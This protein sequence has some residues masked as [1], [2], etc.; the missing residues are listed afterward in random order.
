MIGKTLG[1]FE[2]LGTLGQGGMGSIYRARDLALIA[3][4]ATCSAKF[5]CEITGL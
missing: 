2:I 3:D 4:L 1:H 5:F